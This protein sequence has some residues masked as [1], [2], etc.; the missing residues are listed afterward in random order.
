[1]LCV[2]SDF[3]FYLFCT[4][5]FFNQ[6]CSFTKYLAKKNYVSH[7]IPRCLSSP[8]DH[9]TSFIFTIQERLERGG[10]GGERERDRQTDRQRETETDRQTDRQT[11]RHR[12]R[13]KKKRKKE[14][15]N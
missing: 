11:D 10:G 14:K 3:D 1:M 15:R 8:E 7:G 4:Y 6:K 5:R 12:Q 13:N 2:F 9:V